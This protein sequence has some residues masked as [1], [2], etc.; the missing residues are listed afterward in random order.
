MA[1]VVSTI[2]FDMSS[3]ETIF[4]FGELRRDFGS[5]RF[6]DDYSPGF[7]DEETGNTYTDL[8]SFYYGF[9]V[10]PPEPYN[11]RN[12]T[13]LGDGFEFLRDPSAACG[14][15]A[16]PDS[17]FACLAE[18][19][20]NGGTVSRL[21][22][23]Q[24][25]NDF[26]SWDEV[27]YITDFD[28]SATSL[29]RAV[30]TT[31][32]LDDAAILRQILSG[33]DEFTLSDENDIAYGYDGRDWMDGNR[34]EDLLDG[35]RGDDTI[36]GGDGIDRLIGGLGDDYLYGGSGADRLDGGNG[37]DVIYG[38]E[39]A[40][41]LDGGIGN[42]YLI[43]EADDDILYGGAGADILRGDDFLI[44]RGNDELYGGEG[45]DELYGGLGADHLEGGAGHDLLD[46]GEE[47]DMLIAGA[48]HDRMDGGAGDDVLDGNSGNDTL[49]GGEGMDRLIGG[50]GRDQLT[51][52]A[53]SD[54]FFFR[55][56]AESTSAARDRITDFNA[57]EGDKI[58]LAAIDADSTSPFMYDHFVFIG[59]NAFS[60]DAG[61]LRVFNI[62][63]TGNLYRVEGDTNGDGLA[64]FALDVTSFAALNESDFILLDLI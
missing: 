2:A 14:V 44:A 39:G 3:I 22:L 10:N 5:G 53:G 52:G 40:D 38:S 23:S 29:D 28:Y 48:G 27:W 35:G 6:F 46:G 1:R 42:D 56:T 45:G 58:G 25:T 60:G 63:R 12:F 57:A 8:F 26:S 11:P 19:R 43:G 4:E 41:E 24:W 47:S 20:L 16:D 13:M 37:R 9:T 34:G 49:A 64:D 59:G 17:Q 62:G 51:G 21:S 33:D 18:M 31:T 54:R 50:V 55:S 30:R 61:E 36:R 7:Y 15:L 32:T